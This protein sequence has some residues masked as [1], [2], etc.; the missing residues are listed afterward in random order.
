MGWVGLMNL[1]LLACIT[2]AALLFVISISAQESSF[3]VITAANVRQFHSVLR[4]DFEN[5]PL[6]AGKIE[7]GWFALSPTGNLL[8]SM[9]RANEMV[10]WNA[11]DG[12]VF[13]TYTITGAD[14]ISNPIL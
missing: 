2:L 11:T 5:A 7:N 9:N 6:E 10:V 13:D 8:A 12:S 1:K 4:I 3:P 14:G